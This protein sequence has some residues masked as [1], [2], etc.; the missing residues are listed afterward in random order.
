MDSHTGFSFLFPSGGPY[1]SESLFPPQDAYGV[2]SANLTSTAA[3]AGQHTPSMAV[4][5]TTSQRIE[6]QDLESYNNDHVSTPMSPPLTKLRKR[7]AP[8][9][10]ADDWEPYKH[11]ILELHLDQGVTLKELVPRIETEFGFTATYVFFQ[12]YMKYSWSWCIAR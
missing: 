8:T 4:P 10:R 2:Y 5:A 1:S 3:I 12:F 11:R 7:K 9:L 6:G